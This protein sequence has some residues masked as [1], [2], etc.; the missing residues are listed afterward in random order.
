LREEKCP[1]WFPAQFN[2][3]WNRTDLT[4]EF[5]IK[6]FGQ[7]EAVKRENLPKETARQWF[8]E[9]VRRGWTKKMLMI[10]YDALLS[11]KIFGIEKLDFADWVKAVPV[12][13]MDEVNLLVK[14]KIDAL[15]R[16]GNYLRN[17]KV[18]LTDEEKES[19]E[20]AVAMDIAF[21]YSNSK[22]DLID[23][24]KKIRKEEKLKELK[25]G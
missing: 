11:T 9:F 10:R 1:T 7:L 3:E 16:R 14:Q 24:Y 19:V 13:A 8:I 2:N 6:L 18:E 17:Q 21:Q 15:I 5:C 25:D 12:M 22:L 23:N 4:F 20:A